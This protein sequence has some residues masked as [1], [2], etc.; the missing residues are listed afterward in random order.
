MKHNI[1]LDKSP[2]PSRN[3]QSKGAWTCR[4]VHGLHISTGPCTCTSSKLCHQTITYVWNMSRLKLIF[5][6]LWLVQIYFR[7]SSDH[8]W[9]VVHQDSYI[10]CKFTLTCHLQMFYFVKIY[11]PLVIAAVRDVLPWS[12][13]PTVPMLTWGLLLEKVAFLAG[14]A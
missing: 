6:A 4:N 11:L 12:T 2:L 1:P 8:L 9:L 5:L 14:V 10:L 13:W 7:F 3:K